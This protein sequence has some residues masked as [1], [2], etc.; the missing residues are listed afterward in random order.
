[1]NRTLVIGAGAFLAGMA[2]V[3]LGGLALGGWEWP[4]RFGEAAEGHEGHDMAVPAVEDDR[5]VLYWRAPMDPNFI[6]DR[7]GK[8][9]MG[10]DLVPVYADEAGAQPE[11]TVRLDPGFVQRI[12]VRT[13]PV[14]RRGHRPDDPHRRHPRPQRQSRSPGWAR[15]TTAGSRTWR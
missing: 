11:G 1:M 3:V 5:E 7:P 2:L 13:T 12:G 15:S 4:P 9:P 10:M 6:S 14:E 8:S